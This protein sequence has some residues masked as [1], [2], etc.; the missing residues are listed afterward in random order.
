MAGFKVITE[1]F[2]GKV[3]YSVLSNWPIS[4]LQPFSWPHPTLGYQAPAT[5]GAYGLGIGTGVI[6]ESGSLTF[7]FQA[8]DA[9]AGSIPFVILGS[10]PSWDEQG[11]GGPVR[12]H[13]VEATLVVS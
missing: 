8:T 3:Q 6:T 7:R 13:I 5:V 11:A 2:T 10:Y 9:P 4:G 12:F 1:G